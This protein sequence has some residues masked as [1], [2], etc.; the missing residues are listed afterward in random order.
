MNGMRFL[1]TFS[2]LFFLSISS[3]SMNAKY[4]EARISLNGF[5]QFKTG[6]LQKGQPQQWYSSTFND[7]DWD[8]MEVPGSWELMNE[9]ANYIGIAWYRTSFNTPEISGANRFL[10]ASGYKIIYEADGKHVD[11]LICQSEIEYVL[12]RKAGRSGVKNIAVK[13]F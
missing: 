11:E 4:G 13:A 6:Q 5:C 8:K 1:L 12:L 7:T 9:T 3:H 10:Y 2:L